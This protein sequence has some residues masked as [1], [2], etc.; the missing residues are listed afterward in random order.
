MLT[1]AESRPG[2]RAPATSADTGTE[3]RHSEAAP[4]PPPFSRKPPGPSSRTT[5][6]RAGFR[7]AGPREGCP[8]GGRVHVGARLDPRALVHGRPSGSPDDRCGVADGLSGPASL[9]YEIPKWDGDL[10]RPSLYLPLTEEM[11]HR[12]VEPLHKCFP[13]QASRDWWDD[14]VFL[15]SARLRGWS[16]EP[17]TRKR[18]RARKLSSRHCRRHWGG[19]L[20]RPQIILGAG[21]EEF[22][23]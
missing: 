13:S 21:A 11:A 18:S 14:E 7:R 8:G 12:K 4:P 23:V 3:E 15:G 1:L 22:R 9:S 2:P 10:G 20:K 17:R 16:A 5:Y 19:W 6:P